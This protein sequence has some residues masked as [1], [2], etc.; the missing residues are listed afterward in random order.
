MKKWVIIAVI[1]ALF[2]GG[3]SYSYILSYK[4]LLKSVVFK[5]DSGV[6]IYMF[7]SGSTII[8][9]EI[10]LN[11]TGLKRQYSGRTRIY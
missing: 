9:F 6:N 4:F 11:S 3:E 2:G 10:D 1:I 7:C 8:S 5:V